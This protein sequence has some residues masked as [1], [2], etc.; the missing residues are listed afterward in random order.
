M[1]NVEN[2]PWFAWQADT[3]KAHSKRH[4]FK[5]HFIF[6]EQLSSLLY[7]WKILDIHWGCWLLLAYLSTNS[8]MLMYACVGE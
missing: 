7:M 4:A 5:Y 8:W 3:S 6:C 1:E 2:V